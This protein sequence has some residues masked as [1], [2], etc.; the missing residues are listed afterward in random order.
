VAAIRDALDSA[1]AARPDLT[2]LV[3]HEGAYCDSLPCHGEIVDLARELDST[4]VQFIVSGH[5]HSLVNTVVHGIPIVQSRANGTAY[6]ITDLIR[7]SDGAR[8]WVTR[9]ETVWA[10]RVAPDPGVDALLARYRPEVE[11]LSKQVVAVLRD[12][13]PALRGEY[14]LGNLIADA[15]RAAAPGIDFALMNNGGIRRDLYPGPLTY[16]D[17]FELQP[18]GNSLLE[19]WLSGAQLKDVIEH[20]L[21][22]GSPDGHV[23]GLMVR[24]DSR[25]PIGERVIELRRSD[26]RP[27]EPGATYTIV[28]TDFL[29]SGGGGYAMLRT[30]PMH[31]TGK[32]DLDAL[33]AWL[34]TVKQPV[35]A[36]PGRRFTDVAR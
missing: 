3:A 8:R 17:L 9:I 1:R 16:N 4:Q 2:I 14:P 11:K 26:G 21:A 34:G 33:I 36:P 6:G 27:I 5:T 19:V 30:L 29:Q 10:D 32:T 15:Q 31:R 23:S 12:S 25:R 24:Y 20:A 22:G 35:L 28:V 18:F 7:N 13:L